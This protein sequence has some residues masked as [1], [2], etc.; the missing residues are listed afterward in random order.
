M[1]WQKARRA[2]T[3]KCLQ[4]PLT[5]VYTF[6]DYCSQG[7]TLSHVI[8]DIASPPTSTLSLFNLYVVLSRS[9]G[10]HSI[11][12]LREFDNNVFRKKHDQQLLDEDARL[13][14]LDT[15]TRCWYELVAL[16]S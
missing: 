10:R 2:L 16:C 7:Q 8:V 15:E 12:L 9:A 4:F 6:T 14:N 13:A 11:R 5:A 3:I 1:L